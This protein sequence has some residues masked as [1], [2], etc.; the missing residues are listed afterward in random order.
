MTKLFTII[1]KTM[2]Y[3]SAMVG[4]VVLFTMARSDFDIMI[5][6]VLVLLFVCSIFYD[7]TTAR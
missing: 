5:G 3:T 4:A 6:C 2:I 7:F 1:S